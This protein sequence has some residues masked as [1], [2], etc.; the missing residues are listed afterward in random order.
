[1]TYPSKIKDGAH[2][3]Q[4]PIRA[5]LRAEIGHCLVYAVTLIT[6]NVNDFS[7]RGVPVQNPYS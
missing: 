6:R 2:F 5:Q 1:V 3:A 7:Q 4:G